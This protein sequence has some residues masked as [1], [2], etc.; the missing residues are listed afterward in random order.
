MIAS[1]SATP[2]AADR[3]EKE[4]QLVTEKWA[5][6]V[7]TA[8]TQ[9]ERLTAWQARPD[10]A[11]YAKQM[12]AA[13]GQ[14]L[15]EE[16]SL[17]PAAWF[18]RVTPGL[19]TTKADG[20]T[21]P[22]F[23]EETNAIRDSIENKHLNSNKLIPVCVA[24]AGNTDP[25][26]LSLLEKIEAN[27]PDSKTQGVAALCA[28]MTL[29]S[30][31]DETDLLRKRLTYLRKAIIQSADVEINKVSIAKLAEDELY[32]I[33]FLTKGRVAPDLT[34]VDSAK[35]PM[36]LSD[37]QGKVIVLLFWNSGVS[38]A[39]RVLEI[40]EK[41]A[42]KFKDRPFVLVGVN[43]DPVDKLR[44]MQADSTVTWP[45]FSDPEN[46]L[47]NEY[48]VT[49]WPIAYV[50]DGKRQIH[51]TGSPGSFVELTAEALLSETKAP[52]SE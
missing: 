28:A 22:S 43:N 47:A 9:N 31:G 51:Y 46:R 12:W 19:V 45:N 14:S 33:R 39:E 20:S 32:I 34:G 2:A 17:E 52:V 6:Q 4:Y 10:P 50:L 11:I 21:T 49:S 27:H 37:H 29:K 24:L 16:W 15:D 44:S 40:S 26:S 8:A 35:R 18:L 7:R 38:D 36:K 5:L 23:L 1:A 13:I 3:V 48:R 30:L 42:A 41:L 25:R